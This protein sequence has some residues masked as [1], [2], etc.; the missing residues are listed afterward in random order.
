MSKFFWIANNLALD[1]ANTLAV[2]ENGREL[3]LLVTFDDL[4]A[5]VVESGQ[6][7]ESAAIRVRD[8]L[9]TGQKKKMVELAIGFRSEMKAMAKALA[10]SKPVP[11]SVIIRINELLREKEGHFEL[12]Q[13]A[14]GYEQK[15]QV[16]IN[17]VTDF[18]LPIAEAAMDLLCY[19]DPARVKK[20]EGTDCVLYFYDTSKPGHRRWC[21]MTACGNR[22]KAKAFYQ[23]NL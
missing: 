8:I 1:L 19:G 16:K 23:R 20:C 17:N 12:I 18:L 15:F 13:T 21:S 4:L 2:D 6:A 14:T 3:E 11:R 5:W 7:P 22:A 9:N 10:A